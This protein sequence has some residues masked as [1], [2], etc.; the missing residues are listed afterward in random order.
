MARC[1]HSPEEQGLRVKKQ[2]QEGSRGRGHLGKQEAG[3]RPVAAPWG[4]GVFSQVMVEER[5]EMGSP[6]LP[7]LTNLILSQEADAPLLLQT[8]C[9]APSLRV[10]YPGPLSLLPSEICSSACPCPRTF[11][12]LVPSSWSALPSVLLYVGDWLTP[13][14]SRVASFTQP[15]HLF[16]LS[17]LSL[18]S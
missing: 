2:P 9:W 6:V 1:G 11:A 8:L 7:P 18:V 4:V 16:L 12:L 5:R 3:S 13:I 17:T 14:L 15:S 10:N